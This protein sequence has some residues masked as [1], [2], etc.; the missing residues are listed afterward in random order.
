MTRPLVLTLALSAALPGFALA[1][2]G[3]STTPPTPTE[4]T[5]QCA[6]GQVF[7]TETGAC[8]AIQQDSNAAPQFDQ[9]RAY[10]LVRELAYAERYA[11]AQMI[12]ATMDQADDRTQT[13]WGFTHRKLGQS[14]RAMAAYYT[15]LSANPDNLL[16]R[17]YMGQ[18]YVEIGAMDM[19]RLQLT[20][21]RARGG[22]ESWPEK[23]L[24]WAIETGRGESY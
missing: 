22:R 18:H 5:T 15:A 7:D 21:I 10:A 13:Y 6:E 3:M 14:D 8:V 4:T 24:A 12:L 9:E 1:A 2:G 23:S 17:S 19:A 11:D 20:E 16:A